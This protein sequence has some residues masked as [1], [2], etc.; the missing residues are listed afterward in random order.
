MPRKSGTS[1]QNRFIRGLVTEATA[2]S[3]P[4]DAC[5]EVSNIVFSSTGRVTRR[6]AFDTEASYVEDAIS[7]AAG[8][9]YTSF[10]W[11][12]VSGDG[13]I[14]FLVVQSG[15]QLQFY[16]V[17]SS[18]SVSTNKHTTEINLATFLA[19]QSDKN[20]ADYLCQ[21]AAG[22]GDLIVV[23]AACDPFYVEYDVATDSFNSTIITLQY[24][25]FAGLDDGLTVDQRLTSSLASLETSN[26]EHYYNLL[27]Q[28]WGADTDS[29]TVGV[30]TVLDEWDNARTDLPSNADYRGLYRTDNED[31]FGSALVESND[32]GNRPAPKGHYILDVARDNRQEIVAGEGY[33]FVLPSTNET[34]IDRT[35]GTVIGD[36]DTTASNVFDGNVTTSGGKLS[37]TPSDAYIGKDFGASNGKAVS[38]VIVYPAPSEGFLQ[39]STGNLELDLYASNTLPA[40]GTDGTLLGTSGSIADTTSSVSIATSDALTEYRY[41]WIYVDPAAASVAGIFVGE[42][43]FFST[44]FSFERPSCVDFFAGR[45]FYGG[46][47]DHGISNNIYFTQIIEDE[48]QYGKCFQKNDPTDEHIPDLLPDDG[49]V[50]KIPEMGTLTKLYSYQSALLAFASNGVWLISGSSGSFFK[51][52]DYQVK[53]ISSIGMNS[54]DSCV[55]LK[56]LPA[57]WGEDGI[58]TIQFDPNYDSF[59]PISLTLDSIDTYYRDIPVANRVYVKGA[60]D[61]NEQVAYWLYSVDTDISSDP[62]RYDSVLCLDGKTRAFYVWEIGAGPVVRTVDFIKPADRSES[63]LLKFMIHRSYTGSAANQTFAEVTNTSYLD[64]QVEGTEV[65][66]DSYFVTGYKLD[67]ETQKFFQPNYVFVFLEAEDNA[68][69]YMQGIY[70]FTTSS[71]TG[72]WSTRQQ[73]YNENLT[74]RGVNFRRLKV[75]GKG[76]ALQL[77]FES[78][79]GKPFTIIGWSIFESV[80]S[81]L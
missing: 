34:L 9:V 14:S 25:D 1:I 39:S 57:W 43:Q 27:N 68:S 60:Y 7:L 29:A 12:A 6:N 44:E 50:I 70:D 69:C 35:I 73:I 13:N 80:N 30:N 77:R 40:N 4:E 41:F 51:A 46:I 37:G 26:P 81:G 17:S 8:D 21:F 53:K 33:S 61:E 28:G 71:A 63:G 75:R 16:N 15:N 24:R 31:A 65:D 72:K 52:D 55:S 36:F 38:K 49:G 45:V 20:P 5:T 76:R 74:N 58:Y 78:E 54:P 2:L 67:G 11:E 62:Y 22:D 42:L 59:T 19:N 10:L 18:T 48:Q 3:F 32:P 23:N 47:Q 66:Y 56:G 79:S 64:W